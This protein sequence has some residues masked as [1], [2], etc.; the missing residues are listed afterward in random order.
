MPSPVVHFE[1]GC[2]DAQK[3]AKFY[4]DLFGWKVNQHGSAAM[5]DTGEKTGIQGHANALGHPPHNYCL[6]YAQVDDLEASLA[7]A[8]RLGGKRVVPP[9]EVP[10]M[11]TFAWLS[12]PEGTLCGLWK[13]S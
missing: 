3:T 5:F 12:D 4:S 10:G 11:G 9:T 6:V 1:I 2:R 13:P 7:K 8:E